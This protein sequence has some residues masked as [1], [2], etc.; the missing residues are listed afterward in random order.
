MRSLYPTTDDKLAA[1][2]DAK[3][4]IDQ[5]NQYKEYQRWG[6]QFGDISS[7]PMH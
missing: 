1:A 2:H 6:T 4:F 3:Q 5:Q 7:D